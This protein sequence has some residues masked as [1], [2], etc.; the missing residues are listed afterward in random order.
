GSGEGDLE[1]SLNNTSVVADH[2]YLVEFNDNNYGTLTY[3]S[4][5]S[6]I[7]ELV[8]NTG[9]GN[10]T[11]TD[12]VITETLENNPGYCANRTNFAGWSVYVVYEDEQ[13]PLNQ[14][15]LFQGLQINNNIISNP[16]LNPANNAFNGTNTFTN[17][18]TFYNGDLDVYDIQ[19]NIAIGDTSVEI[20]LTTGD[21]DANGVFQ[22]DLI[23]INNI[24]T[25]LNS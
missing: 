18:N 10:Y 16:P 21:Y 25:V 8:T 4:C 9:T 2:N 6:D 1:V 12:L 14:V 5:V 19:D 17:S 23:I 3:F 22:A 13:L 11:L 24:I 20:K 7:T 15:N